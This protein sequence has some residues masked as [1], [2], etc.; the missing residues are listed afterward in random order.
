MIDLIRLGDATDHAGKVVSASPT[1]SYGDIAVARK[2]DRITCPQHP[3]VRPNVIEEG[4]EEITDE[5]VPVARAGHRCTC[6]C[7]LISSVR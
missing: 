5:G 6:G 3:E 1:M 4:D 7:H 2:G